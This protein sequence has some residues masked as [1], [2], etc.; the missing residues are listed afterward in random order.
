MTELMYE[1]ARLLHKKMPG[2]AIRIPFIGVDGLQIIKDEGGGLNLRLEDKSTIYSKAGASAEACSWFG[3]VKLDGVNILYVYGLGLGAYYYAAKKWLQE[4]KSRVL[5]FLEDDEKIIRKFTETEYAREII[6]DRQVEIVY[7]EDIKDNSSFERLAISFVGCRGAFSGLR[8][9]QQFKQEAFLALRTKIIAA[10]ISA[11]TIHE[12]CAER[13]ALDFFESF[14][15]NAFVLDGSCHADSLFNR[16]KNVP[17]VVCGAGPSLNKNASLLRSLGEKALILAG[18]SAINVLANYNVVPHIAG[19]VCPSFEESHRFNSHNV[20]ELPTFFVSRINHGARQAIHGTPLF[21]PSTSGGYA[22]QEWFNKQ[23]GIQDDNSCW[24]GYSVLTFCVQLAV[25]LGGG[26]VIFVGADLAATNMQRYASGVFTDSTFDKESLDFEQNRWEGSLWKSDIYGN[27]TC[28]RWKWLIESDWFADYARKNPGVK[29]INSTEGGIGFDGVPNMP[30]KEAIEQ[31]CKKS[32]DLSGMLNLHIQQS[33]QYHTEETKLKESFETLLQSLKK[34]R[35]LCETC[36]DSLKVMAF[37]ELGTQYIQPVEELEGQLDDLDLNSINKIK[38]DLEESLRVCNHL[39]EQMDIMERKINIQDDITPAEAMDKLEQEVAY[40]YILK[41]IVNVL[42]VK[43]SRAR[44]VW[45]DN[46]ED[47]N[48]ER[49]EA[50]SEQLS[51]DVLKFCTLK[52]AAASH[53]ML[54]E[55][56]LSKK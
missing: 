34:C 41:D 11:S 38:D 55:N 37:H 30:L 52:D 33:P 31:Y 14:Y 17:I 46:E 9:Y 21:L 50:S 43:V 44:H 18:G 51:A 3:G 27:K 48:K 56:I 54:L 5:V 24:T 45:R 8:Y 19:G 16:F 12:E 39:I 36:E 29:F 13:Y 4:D 53:V 2:I 25:A 22:V 32:Y 23:F 6:Q 1:N 26:P 28:T 20:F 49:I 47:E 10:G 42:N 35:D 7:L 15:Q 40:R